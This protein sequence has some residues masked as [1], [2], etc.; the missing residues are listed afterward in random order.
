MADPNLTQKTSL[1]A[2]SAAPS[3]LYMRAG[4]VYGGSIASQQTDDFR[5]ARQ[6]STDAFM[7]TLPNTVIAGL[8]SVAESMPGTSDEGVDALV[9]TMTPEG[10]YRDYKNKEGGYKL[11]GGLLASVPVIFAVPKLMRAKSLYNKVE[12]IAGAKTAKVLLP[13]KYSVSDRIKEFKEKV[14]VAAKKQTNTFTQ[15]TTQEINAAIKKNSYSEMFDMLKIGIATD[16]GIYA[17]Q[18]NNEFLFP[19]EMSTVEIA[20]F[21][22]IPNLVLSGAAGAVVRY[23]MKNVL[24]DAGEIVGQARNVGGVPVNDAT[25]V[26]GMRGVAAT[27]NFLMAN[28]KTQELKEAMGD[29]LAVKNISAQETVYTRNGLEQAR[30]LGMDSVYKGIT[31]KYTLSEAGLNTVDETRKLYPDILGDVKSVENAKTSKALLKKYTTAKNSAEQ[32]Y[33]FSKGVLDLTMPDT[34]EYAKILKETVKAKE[35]FDELAQLTL[36]K[37]KAD[38][39]MQ[40]AESAKMTFGEKLTGKTVKVSA[41]NL[42]EKFNK[43]KVGDVVEIEM[44]DGDVKKAYGVKYSVDDTKSYLS[45]TDDFRLQVPKFEA[46]TPQDMKRVLDDFAKETKGYLRQSLRDIGEVYHF[47]YGQLGKKIF[48]DL[49]V[50]ASNAI[51]R[52]VGKSTGNIL[53]KD[54]ETGRA[55]VDEIYKAYAPVRQSFREI[56]DADGLIPALRGESKNESLNPSNDLVSMTFSLEVARDFALKSNGHVVGVRIDP[57]DIVA[58]VGGLRDEFEIIVKGGL[59]RG[60]GSP[61]TRKTYEDLSFTGKTAAQT[62]LKKVAEKWKP[63]TNPTTVSANAHHTQLDAVLEVV[64]K[65]GSNSKAIEEGFH[66]PKNMS[67]D[68]VEMLSLNAKFKE[69]TT[70]MEKIG[71]QAENLIKLPEGQISTLDDLLIELNLPNNGVGGMTPLVQVF[72]NL[73]LQGI[74][75]LKPDY[76]TLEVFQK[77]LEKVAFPAGD[78]AANY[79]EKVGVN[80]RGQQYK[81]FEKPM[82]PLILVTKSNEANLMNK[83]ELIAETARQ[84]SEIIDNLKNGHP[85]IAAS[86]EAVMRDPERFKLAKA[87]DQVVEG[88]RLWSDR[89]TQAT[90]GLRNQGPIIAQDSI[91]AEVENIFKADM[92]KQFE[93]FN[94]NF[95]KLI[96]DKGQSDFFAIAVHQNGI[97][98]RN[99]PEFVPVMEGE[100]LIGYKLKLEDHATN[101]RMAKEYYDIDLADFEKATGEAMYVPSPKLTKDTPYSPM[102]VPPLAAEA[103][104]AINVLSQNSRMVQNALRTAVSM[105]PIAKKA[106]HLV[107]KNLAAA[108]KKFL[109][110]QQ[111][112]ELYSIAP[113]NTANQAATLAAEEV[114]IAKKQGIDLFVASDKEVEQFSLLQLNDPTKMIDYSTSFRQTGA[115]ARGV[116]FGKT[117]EL[118]ATVLQTMQESLLKQS[119]LASRVTSSIIF[120]PEFR[121][122]KVAAETSGMAA[123]TLAKGTSNFDSYIRRGLGIKSGN[124]KQTIGKFYGTVEDVYDRLWQ[125]AW[126]QKISVFKGGQTTVQAETGFKNLDNSMGPEY[127]PFKDSVEFLENTMRIKPPQNMLK[128]MSQLNSITGANLLRFG[129]VG[130]GLVNILTLPTLIP[131]VARALLPRK[132]E[133]LKQWKAEVGAWGSPINEGEA[134]WSPVRASISGTHFFFSKEGQALMKEASAKGHLWQKAV[135][136]LQLFTSP[137]QGYMQR[138]VS[139]NV[140]RASI[141]VDKTEEWSRGIS[142]GVF[143]KLGKDR[144]KLDHDA[145]MEFAHFQANKVIG[146]FRPNVRPQMFQGAAGM[147]FGLFTTFA[148]NYMQ[149]VFSYVEKGDFNTFFYQMGLQSSFFG[150]KSLPG[151]NQYV[152]SFSSNYDGSENMVDR[153]Q[154]N[155]GTSLTDAVLFGGVGSLTGLAAYSRTEIGLPGSN[156]AR[157]QEITS[158]MP[159]AGMIK[160]AYTGISE[161]LQSLKA[162]DGINSRE[163]MEIAGRTFP[164]SAVKGWIQTG[165]GQTV[166]SRGQLINENIDTAIERFAKISNIKTLREQLLVEEF[167][168]IRSTEMKWKDLRGRARKALRASY[169]SGKLDSD[170][171]NKIAKDYLASNGQPDDFDN[172]LT[173]EVEA[174]L[175]NKGYLRALMQAKKVSQVDQMMRMINILGNKDYE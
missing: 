15:E 162:N 78:L 63:G 5:T 101:S 39:S 53:R 104:M 138:M 128:H 67:W 29:P 26:P 133:N 116:S 125:K 157:T 76:P 33:L 112:G 19:E 160:R 14:E 48:T 163:L 114:T 159:A 117:I 118:G 137:T 44:K 21:Y 10:M 73:R 126:D 111:T 169:R 127:N 115:P 13:N 149:R 150:A 97:G 41:S 55:L 148:W 146:D 82:E 152:D 34:D 143:Y 69:Y 31:S 74:K 140:D 22:G 28:N 36:I 42:E 170:S 110:N 6:K 75:D 52:W 99:T 132:G 89:A 113:G 27:N 93:P 3:E 145:A 85:V 119:A 60:L 51:D 155:L 71:K 106:F 47:K 129:E 1:S 7:Y 17:T 172:F 20:A 167:A 37:L 24:R 166:D 144:L 49:S 86:V 70:S 68:D 88:S 123:S 94:E 79:T 83:A 122:A 54:T 59:K 134:L 98:W 164:T 23:Q 18:N 16:A 11:A 12:S 64:N 87:V 38:G 72:E 46:Q 32:E 135:E 121:A 90:F 130:L 45:A 30:L 35:T 103:L 25:S 80:L 91:R 40:L 8:A 92:A 61:I 141:I 175:V 95:N 109:I 171:L 131:V 84:R 2:N 105:K 108:E 100:K 156:F 57:N 4:M 124:E 168:R 158:M 147:P 173:G 151:F 56:A 81:T 107:P 120:D 43:V 102:V 62:A 66:L 96:S 165:L 161:S 153:M 139:K 154:A 50:E 174:A 58:V 9:Q 65:Y 77:E 142:Y 136:Q